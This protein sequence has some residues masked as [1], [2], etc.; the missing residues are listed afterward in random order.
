MGGVKKRPVTAQE[1]AQARQE[2]EEAAKAKQKKTVQAKTKSE[3]FRP[4]IF[5]EANAINQ[6]KNI[7]ALTLY[8]VARALNVP[9]SIANQFLKSLESKGIIAKAGGFS[10]HYIYKFTAKE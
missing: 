2:A 5:D 1:K 8:S 6:I 10:G 7:K 9:A 3:E 4:K